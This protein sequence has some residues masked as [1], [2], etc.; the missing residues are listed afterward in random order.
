[1]ALSIISLNVNGPRESSKQE[2]LIQWLQSHPV[3]VDVVCLQEMHRISDAECHSWFSSSGLSFDLSPGTSRSGSCII[4][5]RS[6]LKLVNSWCEVP[7]RSL[8][9]EFVLCSR[10][11]TLFVCP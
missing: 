9:C 2:G 8:L 7:S 10:S 3:M 6:V 11:C 4:L 1:M 5:Y